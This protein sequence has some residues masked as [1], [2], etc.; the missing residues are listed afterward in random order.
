MSPHSDS[1]LRLCFLQMKR[2]TSF[3]RVVSSIGI[4]VKLES[5]AGRAKTPARD[6]RPLVED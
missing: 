4:V 5:S 3:M 1:L 2:I 6:G